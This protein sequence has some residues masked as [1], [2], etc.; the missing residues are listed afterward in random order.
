MRGSFCIPLVRESAPSGRQPPHHDPAHPVRVFLDECGTSART[1]GIRK[2]QPDGSN[3]CTVGADDVDRARLIKRGAGTLHPHGSQWRRSQ[4]PDCGPD[5]RE[6]KIRNCAPYRLRWNPKGNGTPFTSGLEIS[7]HQPVPDPLLLGP[8]ILIGDAA[9]RIRTVDHR[10]DRAIR[11]G[12]DHPVRSFA[13]DGDAAV[14]KNAPME[15]GRKAGRSVPSCLI[16]PRPGLGRALGFGPGTTCEID[17]VQPGPFIRIQ[18]GDDPW[19]RGTPHGPRRGVRS[20]FLTRSTVCQHAEPPA[21]GSCLNF[22]TEPALRRKR[23]QLPGNPGGIELEVCSSTFIY[24]QN[25]TVPCDSN[26][27]RRAKFAGATAGAPERTHKLSSRIEDHDSRLCRI[28]DVQVFCRVESHV[29]CIA[30]RSRCPCGPLLTQRKEHGCFTGEYGVTAGKGNRFRSGRRFCRRLCTGTGF[31]LGN[32][33]FPR[34]GEQKWC[35]EAVQAS[36]AGEHTGTGT[37]GNSPESVPS[38]NFAPPEHLGATRHADAYP[39]R[40]SPGQQ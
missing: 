2:C 6:A 3:V 35:G 20:Q 16:P 22:G 40:G 25:T 21:A 19:G 5:F 10:P 38:W 1:D 39:H 33:S 4:A 7:A 28:Q 36:E 31:R 26:R 12:E 18:P 32:T 11:S 24:D 27:R 14:G 15:A 23:H 17:C 37:Y 8:A 9:L 29:G 30:W 13:G 34:N